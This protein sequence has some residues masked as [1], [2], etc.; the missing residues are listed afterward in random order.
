MRKERCDTEK[1]TVVGGSFFL[2]GYVS[3]ASLAPGVVML[4]ENSNIWSSEIST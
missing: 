3:M 1:Y 4:N 2:T